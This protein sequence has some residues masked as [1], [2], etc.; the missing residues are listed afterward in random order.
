MVNSYGCDV[1][2]MEATHKDDDP[3]SPLMVAAKTNS[4]EA[5]NL[6]LAHNADPDK[7]DSNDR[8]ALTYAINTNSQDNVKSLIKLTSVELIR[9][10]KALAESDLVIDQE[11]G[12][13]IIEKIRAENIPLKP[14]LQAASTFGKDDFIKLLLDNFPE[15]IDQNTLNDVIKNVI[16]SDQPKACKVVNDFMKTKNI[17]LC[18]DDREDIVSRGKQGVVEAFGVILREDEQKFE[19][20]IF[21]KVIKSNEF[22]YVENIGKVKKNVPKDMFGKEEKVDFKTMIKEVGAPTVHYH[23]ECEERCPQTQKCLY[24]RQ[25]LNFISELFKDVAVGTPLFR[26]LTRMVVGSMKENTKIG[27]VDEIDLVFL[28]NEIYEKKYFKFDEKLQ[29]IVVNTEN[30]PAEFSKFI[31]K[32]GTFNSKKYFLTFVVGMRKAV[33]K[34]ERGMIKLPPG[35]KLSTKFH[36]CEVCVSKEDVRPQYVRCKH[37]P[38]CL[39]HHKRLGQGCKCREFTSPSITFSKIGVVLHLEFCDE[40]GRPQLNLDVDISPPTLYVDNQDYDGNNVDKR[41]W[42]RRKRPLDWR[43]E[44]RKSPDMTEVGKYKNLRRSVRFRRISRNVV[45]PEQVNFLI[46]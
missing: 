26:D 11:L 6:L 7:V 32:D 19:P 15:A 13:C 1:N 46:T 5:I 45:I 30:L 35:L 14:L 40:E 20:D 23:K 44:Y 33:E 18:E 28:L 9:S 43:T 10:L 27:D 2:R 21:D 39:D 36:P 37:K 4:P 41:A 38:G 42:L 17:L 3:L 24:I 34:A 29:K 12:E 31:D 8:T 25:S 16:K 22:S